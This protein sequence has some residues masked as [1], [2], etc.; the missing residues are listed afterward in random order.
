MKF[1]SLAFLATPALA[2]TLKEALDG[3][4]LGKQFAQ[5]IDGNQK[6]QDALVP[7]GKSAVTLFLPTDN[8]LDKHTS[9]APPPLRRSKRQQ[10]P[11]SDREIAYMSG[12]GKADLVS[13]SQDK[14]IPSQSVDP[15]TGKQ[16]ITL[17]D[18]TG[19]GKQGQRLLARGNVSI[20]DISMFGGLG[21][22]SKIVAGDI[23]FDCGIIHFVDTILDV[24]QRCSS[25]IKSLGYKN[26]LDALAGAGLLG[27]IDK[28]DTTVFTY[29]DDVFTPKADRS[30]KTLKQ[31]IVPNFVAYSPV[32]DDVK[33]LTTAANT[34]LKVRFEYGQ[35]FINDSP[36]IKSNII[37][38]NGVV[39][40]LGKLLVVD[41]IVP[42]YPSS[43]D[44]ASGRANQMTI[45]VAL[46]LAAWNYL[47]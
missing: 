35:Y 27:L 14:I 42:Y 28:P 39:H 47:V 4:S 36:I 17:A 30:E 15:T 3:Q 40:T 44:A 24:P 20:P 29:A 37:C 26:F 43:S 16:D 22:K 1:L 33:T 34:T 7:P 2:Q 45:V 32:L 11:L 38:N 9:N 10:T 46:F 6:A 31:H 8:A 41:K 21:A 12:D 18:G 25:S 5:Q 23:E 13:L 19:D